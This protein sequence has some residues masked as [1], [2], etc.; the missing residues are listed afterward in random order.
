MSIASRLTQSVFSWLG[1]RE[2]IQRD[3][4][5]PPRT[6]RALDPGK[7]PRRL[8]PEAWDVEGFRVLTLHP[9]RRGKGQIFFLPGG[10][11]L[12]E[13]TPFH[14]RM[15][16]LLAEDLGFSVSLLS[17][18]LA[19]E[20]SFHTTHRVALAAFRALEARFPGE[21]Y[22]LLGD[23]AGG[24]LGLSL[25]QSLRDLNVPTRPRKSVLISPWVDLS[26]S[27]PALNGL[28]DGDPFLPLEGLKYAADRISA[29]EDLKNPSLSP[30]YGDLS[31]LGSFLL[32][33]G[34]RELLYPDCLELA[35][36]ISAASGSGVETVI[37]EGLFHDWAIFPLPESQEAVR[38][39]SSF[40]G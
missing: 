32:F 21:D 20:H 16:R 9:A 33:C 18:P 35:E 3:F 29:G 26:L 25:L 6:G 7:F 31:G 4:H 14:A 12:L 23:S 28:A 24:G 5:N 37:G 10:A 1:F 22:F 17:Y 2:K 40:F 8:Q 19:P 13:P 30:L 11:Y 36:K 38:K 39:I 34:T 15:A 27:N